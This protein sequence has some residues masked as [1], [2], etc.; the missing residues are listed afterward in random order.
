[1]LNY[2]TAIPAVNIESDLSVL[3]E[4]PLQGQ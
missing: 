2:P 4:N 1:M 3:Q